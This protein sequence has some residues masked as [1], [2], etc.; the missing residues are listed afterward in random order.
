MRED[1]RG[2]LE[3]AAVEGSSE[4]CAATLIA[5][6]PSTDNLRNPTFEAFMGRRQYFEVLKIGK[7]D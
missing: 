5:T 1:L 3:H 2:D 7:A 6:G 4:L